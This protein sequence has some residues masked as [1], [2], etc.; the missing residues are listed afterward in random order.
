VG[1]GE[2]FGHPG[3]ARATECLNFWV[4]SRISTVSAMRA[5]TPNFTPQTFKECSGGFGFSSC[6]FQANG[7]P[8]RPHWAW[9][10]SC[11]FLLSW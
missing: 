4:P 11:F 5:P 2:A 9:R 10:S 6:V 3:Q 8:S 1:E 7:T